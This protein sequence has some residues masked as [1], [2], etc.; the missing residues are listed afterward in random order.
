LRQLKIILIPLVLAY[1]TILGLYVANQRKLIYFP[2]KLDGT[3]PEKYGLTQYREVHF[4]SAE[5]HSAD[6]KGVAQARDLTGWWIEHPDRDPKRPVLLYCH[7]NAANLSLLS[8]VAKIFYDFG[9]DAL[10]FD[11]RSYGNSEKGPLS[12]EALGN[13]ALGAY[14]WLL[15]RKVRPDRI[16]L[17]GHSLGSG[18]AARLATRV[19]PAGLILE[20]ALPSVRDVAQEKYPWLLVPEFLI[21]DNFQTEV[22]VAQRAC[23][24]LQFHAEKDSIIPIELGKKVYESAVPPKRWMVVEGIDHNDFPSVAYRYKKPI[25]D[26]VKDCLSHR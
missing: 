24:L 25:M 19:G 13:D 8:E 9:F 12:E 21:W 4:P 17:W 18:V 23:P 10:L 7:G 26:F 16:I 11:Y 6:K 14:H 1:L 22:Y 2:A 3:T 15:Q 5:V 20:G